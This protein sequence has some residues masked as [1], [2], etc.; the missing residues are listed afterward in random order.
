MVKKK[1]MPP[2]RP[3]REEKVKNEGSDRS[4]GTG[5]PWEKGERV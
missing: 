2:D 1:A 5:L 3:S 4:C